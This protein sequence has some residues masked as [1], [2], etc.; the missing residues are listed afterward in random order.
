MPLNFGD[1]IKSIAGNATGFVNNAVDKTV[2]K[3]VPYQAGSPAQEQNGGKFQRFQQPVVPQQQQQIIPQQQAPV[4]YQQAQDAARQLMQAGV[5]NGNQQEKSEKED[6]AKRNRTMANAISGILAGA[7]GPGGLRGLE[8]AMGMM[9]TDKA[10]ANEAKDSEQ[11]DE[12]A[13]DV[14]TVGSQ[15]AK[16]KDES[17]TDKTPKVKASINPK[18]Q[19]YS[20]PTPIGDFINAYANVA[21]KPSTEDNVV[22]TVNMA[23]NNGYSLRPDFINQYLYNSGLTTPKELAQL[24]NAGSDIKIDENYSLQEARGDDENSPLQNAINET[25]GTNFSVENADKKKDAEESADAALGG[26]YGNLTA[27]DWD[28]MTQRQQ[29]MWALAHD[30][31]LRNQL[32]GI[33]EGFGADDALGAFNEETSN[34]DGN[35][36]ELYRSLDRDQLEQAVN[37]VYGLWDDD[38][39]TGLRGWGDYTYGDLASNMSAADIAAYMIDNGLD[40]NQYYSANGNYDWRSIGNDA[41][42]VDMMAKYLAEQVSDPETLFKYVYG[43]DKS[44]LNDLDVNDLA[45]LIL[46]DYQDKYGYIGKEDASDLNY[47][48]GLGGELNPLRSVELSDKSGKDKDYN[49][50]RSYNAMKSLATPGGWINDDQGN[51]MVDENGN[52]INGYQLNVIPFRDPMQGDNPL[53]DMYLTDTFAAQYGSKYKDKKLVQ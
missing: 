26:I 22:N 25:L 16:E 35:A 30:E 14:E 29:F 23:A 6:K 7:A 33:N 49:Q 43:A 38:D 20:D 2:G 48:L 13:P 4:A 39:S 37:A 27:N 11:K 41:V 40:L 3:F 31:D 53:G 10:M 1:V 21:T 12:V 46:A 47:L 19:D 8:A 45:L 52:P 36:Y 50:K 9:P 42:T 28:N 34:Y 15:K 17:T 5:S 18:D 44:E 24:A 51:P 32:I